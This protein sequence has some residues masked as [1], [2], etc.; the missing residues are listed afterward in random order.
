MVSGFQSAYCLIGIVAYNAQRLIDQ[1]TFSLS[2]TLYTGVQRR[3]TASKLI[4]SRKQKGYS[5]REML[6]TAPGAILFNAFHRSPLRKT[7]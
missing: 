1:G 4:L 7:P 3:L 6:G 5:D 2:S